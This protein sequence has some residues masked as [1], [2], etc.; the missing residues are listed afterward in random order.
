MPAGSRLRLN[1]RWAV[2]AALGFAVAVAHKV[3]SAFLQL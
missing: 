2:A 3:R 1:R